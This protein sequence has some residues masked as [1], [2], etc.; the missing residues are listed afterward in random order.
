MI[1]RD[2]L[3]CPDVTG[4]YVLGDRLRWLFAAFFYKIVII[5]YLN[6][7]EQEE[8]VLQ[9]GINDRRETKQ[10]LGI[11]AGIQHR[12]R[13]GHTGSARTIKEIMEAEMEKH[14]GYEKSQRS[15]S[16]DARN[17]YKSK[18][19]T[20][21]YGGMEIEVPQ[22]RKSTFEP[23]VV[24]KRQKDITEIY[25]KI[26]SMYSKGMTTRQIFATL[27]DIYGFEASE[28]FISDVT[29]KLL[30]QKSSRRGL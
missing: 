3:L 10:P 4:N 11:A 16:D 7:G 27:M 19:I 2:R 21:S 25:Q 9:T 5:G 1:I 15:D 14:L 6:Y 22:N 29:D 12:K 23:T 26:I 17:G 8:R 30:R 24:K 28:G 18:R 20:T 13:R